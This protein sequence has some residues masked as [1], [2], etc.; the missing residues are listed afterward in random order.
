MKSNQ[1]KA[2]SLRAKAPGRY[3][4][5]GGLML[6]VKESG[7]RS[8]VLRVM[9]NGVRRD[10]GL[11]SVEL[12]ERKPGPVT[13]ALE[14][15]PIG[16]RKVLTLREARLKA[17]E[18]RA[19]IKAGVDPVAEWEKQSV[20][21]PTFEGKAR[22]YHEANKANWRNEKHRA[23]WLS[24]LEDYA[25]PTLGQ[26]RVDEID[27]GDISRALGSIWLSK[28][29]TADRTQQRICAVLTAAK[30]A[31]ERKDAVPTAKE[32]KEGLPRRSE[33][34]SRQEEHFA[35]MD[36]RRIPAL[37]QAI[38]A[39]AVTTA[40]LAL[41]FTFYT[42]ARSGEV[43]GMTWDEVD[44]EAATWTIPAERMKKGRAHVVPLSG[45]ALAILREVQPLSSGKA[46]A[47]VFPGNGGTAMSDATMAKAFKLAGGEG[48]TVHGTVRSGFR[49]W[50]GETQS[51][52]PGPVA[53]AVLAH[54]IKDKTERSYHRSSYLDQRKPLMTI[55]A[56]HLDGSNN[57]VELRAVAS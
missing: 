41:L 40:R 17:S 48:F 12:D 18:G 15:L 44:F 8:W 46:R 11:G 38:R 3:T 52:V 21:V 36:Y 25:F 22:D 23:Q 1:L 56:Q 57:V 43:R 32:I 39:S 53:E 24:T 35:A 37:I 33:T 14:A 47:I 50:C 5:G 28:P 49:D 34:N 51:G 54:K 19:L 13:D 29:E 45:S 2:A 4:D 27:A 26:K 30:A 16:R 20:V 42:C 9:V 55:W 6:L 10:I 31:R 7:A